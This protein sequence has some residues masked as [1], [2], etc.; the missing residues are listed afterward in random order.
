MQKINYTIECDGRIYRDVINRS[1]VDLQPEILTRFAAQATT[2]VRNIISSLALSSKLAGNVHM[3]IRGKVVVFTVQLG[4]MPMRARFSVSKDGKT[5]VPDFTSDSI[6][7]S[8]EWTPPAGMTLLLMVSM[9]P[10]TTTTSDQFLVAVDKAGRFYRL[11][12]TNCYENCKLCTGKFNGIGATYADAIGK[13]LN[14]FAAS[15]WQ[16]DLHDRGGATGMTNSKLMFRFK[17]MEPEGF[18]QL[19]PEAEDWT[20]LCTKVNYEF[21]T[22]FIVL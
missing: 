19:P 16:G 2:R 5:M 7:M 22:N 3:A 18:D 11:P 1:E 21:I 4:V 8:L 14:Q 15:E 9:T 13:A 10:D 6:P 17:P 20:A 12:T